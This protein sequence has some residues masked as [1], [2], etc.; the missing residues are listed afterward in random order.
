MPPA[1]TQKAP[2]KPPAKRR[3]LSLW[4]PRLGAD[5]V[6]RQDPQL[7]GEPLAIV[8]TIGNAQ[9]ISSLSI[10]AQHK[11]LYPGQPVRDAHAMCDRLITR[12]RAPLAEARFLAVLRR[13]AGKF[14]PWVAEEGQ[15]GLVVDLTGCAHLFGGEAPLMQ[16]VQ[17]DCH[18]MGLAVQMGLADTRGAAWAL[19]RYAGK[20]AALPRNGD[21]IDQ[22]ARATRSRAGKRHWT[23]GGAAPEMPVD[24]PAPGL[25]I[26]PPGRTYAALAPLPIAALR[27]EADT[28]AQLARL[29]LRQVG[30][31]VGQP[32]AAL[33]RRFGRGLVYRMDQ[34]LGSA[35]EPVSPAKP[36]DHFATRLTLPDP[37]GLA[38]DMLAGIDR[39]L[40]PLCARLDAKSRA[41]RRLRLEAHRTDHG[42]EAI[43]IALARPSTDPPHIRPLLELKLD[44][45]DAGFGIDMLRLEALQTEPVYQTR[46]VGHLDAGKAVADR[47]A[48]T[49][50][51][52]DLLGRLGARVGM[53]AITRL[54]P[55][56]SHIPEKTS[57]VM[58]AAWSKPHDGAWPAPPGPRPVLL[59]PPEIVQAPETPALPA[60]FRWRGRT[61]QLVRGS[62]P[63]R[64]APEWWLDAPEWRTGTRDYWRVTVE[65]GEELWLYFAHGGALSAGWFCQGMFA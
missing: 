17:Q 22:E 18:D 50:L 26:A 7:A 38:E 64:I 45:I 28:T 41:I 39:L 63:E 14:S 58:A 3:I 49:T 52:D 56:S 8:D 34:A 25:R 19:A 51:L 62:G 33:A 20:D 59:W 54:H 4:F 2:A 29:G 23:R 21:A 44:Q 16:V 11:G 46:A 57:K 13:W 15:A 65:S 31:L 47:L 37:I 55:A 1:D 24:G 48:K 12:A 36:A 42:V 32:R 6:V 61:H 30:D 43:E 27:L 53:E 40:P 9:V 35:P 60:T 10:E 5:R